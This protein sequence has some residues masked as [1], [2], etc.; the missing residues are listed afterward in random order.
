MKITQVN[1]KQKNG[2]ISISDGSE[3]I[4]AEVAARQKREGSEP[5]N[6][7]KPKERGQQSSD[8]DMSRGYTVSEQGLVNNY[9][10]T[11]K[12]YAAKYPSPE[13]Q[14]RYIFQGIFAILFVSGIITFAFW[15]S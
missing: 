5:P 15:V 8:I 3:L 11:P 6:N 2:Y 10:I 13:Q 12:T 1:E 7:P 4:P 9:P 14:K